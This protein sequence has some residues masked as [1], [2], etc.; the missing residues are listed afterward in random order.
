WGAVGIQI[1]GGVSP[2]DLADDPRVSI[3]S[4]AQPVPGRKGRPQPRLRLRIAPNNGTAEWPI[5]LHRPLPP[6]GSLRFVKVTAER[7]GRQGRWS[8]HFT[9]NLPDPVPALPEGVDGRVVAVRPTFARVGNELIVAE[10]ADTSGPLP[11]E[12][13]HP[14][15]E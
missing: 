11:A 15:I 9:V 7:L 3:T 4:A 10:M 8:A 5:I 12:A 13:L 2:S 6:E 1:Q 14:A